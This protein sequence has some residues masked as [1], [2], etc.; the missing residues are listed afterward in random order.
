MKPM[1][2]GVANSPA[3]IRSPSFS[4]LSSSVTQMIR[5]FFMASIA[6]S[7]DSLPKGLHTSSPGGAPTFHCMAGRFALAAAI[8]S[9]L[10]GF[11]FKKKL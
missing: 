6:A 4:R 11:E 9:F 2:S 7:T 1:A 5:P 10:E 3:M 8:R